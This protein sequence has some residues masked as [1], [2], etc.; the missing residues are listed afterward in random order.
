[1]PRMSPNGNT[2]WSPR[3]R[4]TS[5]VDVFVPIRSA[6]DCVRQILGHF[7]SGCRTVILYGSSGTGRSTIARRIGD[8]WTGPSRFVLDPP[9]R[10]TPEWLPEGETGRVRDRTRGESL[11]IVDSL[12][13]EHDD[14]AQLID[15]LLTGRQ[16]SLIVSSTAW[17]LEHGRYLPVRLAGVSTK[18]VEADEIE[19]LVNGWR[20]LRNPNAAAVD[21]DFVAEVASHSEGRLSEVARMAGAGVI[22]LK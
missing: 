21:A 15:P 10:F 6:I 12:S 17:W 1:M 18:W 5:G 9:A 14:W 22:G 16:R 13:L 2:E 20:W 3:R 4:V 7:D 8:L 19:H 11:T